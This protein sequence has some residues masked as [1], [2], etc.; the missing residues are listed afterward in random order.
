MTITVKKIGD[1][2]LLNPFRPDTNATKWVV[3]AEREDEFD[4]EVL[5]N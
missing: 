2:T 1:G 3:R 5:E 4:I